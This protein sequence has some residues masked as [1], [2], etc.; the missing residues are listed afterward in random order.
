MIAIRFRNGKI[1]IKWATTLES[2][3]GSIK[4]SGGWMDASQVLPSIQWRPA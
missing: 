3:G 1:Y 4:G 2:H